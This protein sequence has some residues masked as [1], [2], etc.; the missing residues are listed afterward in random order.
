[1]FEKVLG[2]PLRLSHCRLDGDRSCDFEAKPR[3]RRPRRTPRAREKKDPAHGAETNEQGLADRQ[4]ARVHR[5]QGDPQ[6]GRPDDPPGGGPRPDGPQRL[7]QEHPELRPGR[8]PELRGHRGD[9]HPR[10]RRPPGDG[11]RRAGQGGPL[12]GLPVP[13]VDPRRHGRQL[14][15]ARRH[16]RPQPLPQGGRGPDLDARLPQGASRRDGRTGHGPGLRPPLPQRGLLRRREEAGRGPATRH[17][18]ARASPSSTRPTAAW[19]STPCGSSARASTRSRRG[20]ARASWSSPTT[21]ASSTTSSRPT[22]TSSSAARSSRTAGPNWCR[23]SKPR[24]TTGSAA[25]YP[26]A[27]RAEEELEQNAATGQLTF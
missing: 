4:P 11:G 5:R 19:T 6:G 7:G 20:S 2:R 17:A 18:P 25:K 23:S 22:S 10:R 12:P 27:A 26:E 24:A 15:A 1:M 13:D 14:P 8:A 3:R 16:Q 9:G 21:S